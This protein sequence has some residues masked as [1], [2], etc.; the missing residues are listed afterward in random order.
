MKV[1]CPNKN[2]ALVF[3]CPWNSARSS[4]CSLQTEDSSRWS[5]PSMPA[6]GSIAVIQALSDRIVVVYEDRHTNPLVISTPRVHLVDPDRGF[7]MLYSGFKPDSLLVTDHASLVCRNYKYT[8]SEDIPM[9]MLATRIAE[10]KQRFTVDD[11]NRPL[12]LR[13]VLFGIE[14]GTPRIFI[15]E[16]DGNFA[17]YQRFSV[18]YRNEVCNAY[19]ENNGSEDSSFKALLEVVQKDYRKV[20]GFV[21]SRD[22]L[23][24][25]PQEQIRSLMEE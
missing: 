10:F 11:E 23:S 6:Q 15:V 5:M 25:I 13:S 3:A 7:Y 21:L 22:G 12:G 1:I 16:T 14:R 18:G 20:K 19:L 8:T 4:E 17:E 9:V 2:V 24:E